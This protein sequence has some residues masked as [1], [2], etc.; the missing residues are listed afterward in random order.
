VKQRYWPDGIEPRILY[1]PG[2]RGTEPETAERQAAADR[3]L[4]KKRS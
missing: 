1:Q 2:E 4:G 3:I